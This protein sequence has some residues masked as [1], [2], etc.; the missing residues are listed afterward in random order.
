MVDLEECT[1]NVPSESSDFLDQGS[2]CDF[3][4]ADISLLALALELCPL[5]QAS[6][7]GIKDMPCEVHCGVF[8]VVPKLESERTRSSLGEQG[9]SPSGLLK[10]L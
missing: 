10:E 1:Y 9:I 4:E 5:P 8:G 7:M 6:G 2:S 3:E